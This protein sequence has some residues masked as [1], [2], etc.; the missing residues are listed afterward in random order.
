MD[1]KELTQ[2]IEELENRA[3]ELLEQA[4][5]DPSKASDLKSVIDDEIRP[6]LEVLTAEKASKDQEASIKSLRE[7]VSSLTETLKQ[8]KTPTEIFS[9]SKKSVE[10][11][12]E[13]DYS[14]DDSLSYFND[15]R[16]ASK[17][18]SSAID[19]ISKS[20]GS[21]AMTEGTDSAGGFL[22]PPQVVG[23]LLRLRYEANVIRQLVPSL[24][25]SSDSV[26]LTRVASSSLVAEWVD[27]EG[28]KPDGDFV[29]GQFSA[30]IFTAAGLGVVSNQ[31][32]ADAKPGIDGLIISDL[33]VKLAQLEEQSFI[34]GDGDAKP[35]G[36]LNTSGINSI[37]GFTSED[38]DD[39]LDAI[40]DGIT[41]IQSTY[42]GDP[43][44]IM[45]H[46]LDW[47]RIVKERSGDT[48]FIGSGANDVGRKASDGL[49]N[50]S[51]FGTRVV[52]SRNVPTTLGD[53]D[54][55]TAV[56]IGNFKEALILDRQGVTVDSS[57]HVHF[58]TN[59][60][61]F[62]AE[63][64]V[65]FTAERYAKAFCKITGTGLVKE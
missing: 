23:D 42:L 31:L 17:G 59:Q 2:K 6:A 45:M 47:A 48:Y 52:L 20:Y 46:P 55:E 33:A 3:A 57:P 54:N 32:L 34:N 26:Q 12:P 44:C 65:G 41:L 39:L 22:V 35:R 60:T 18:N 4:E 13:V 38:V 11:S 50:R 7:D 43:D 15:V 53:D 40:Y 56:I 58:T 28:E 29:F 21:K 25:V 51:L 49:P 37:S 9:N 24:S 5:T 61:I 16:L 64:R 62:R 36:I 10:D 27:E 14:S 8:V 30:G 63:E 1:P 19:R